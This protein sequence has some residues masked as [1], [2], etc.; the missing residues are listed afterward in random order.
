MIKSLSR[1]ALPV[2]ALPRVVKRAVALAVDASLAVLAVWLAFYL[3]LGE[4]EEYFHRA[5]PSPNGH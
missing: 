5:P 2:L 3:R 1:F 4:S